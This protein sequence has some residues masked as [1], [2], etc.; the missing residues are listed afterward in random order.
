[1]RSP[2][3]LVI[4]SS[5][6]VKWINS[7]DEKYLDTADKIL[8]DTEDNK[9]TLLAPELAKYEIGNAILNK[10]LSVEQ[11]YSSLG[12]IFAIP[13]EFS[14]LT[15]E[16]AHQTSKIASENKITFYDASFLSL[17]EHEGATLVTDNAKHQGKYKKVKVVS[18]KDYR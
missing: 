1:M 18:I 3:K 15:E 5:I 6:A 13:I 4:D 11:A 9:V 7:Q 10:G 16:L 8:K 17:A 14:P 12:T 2:K